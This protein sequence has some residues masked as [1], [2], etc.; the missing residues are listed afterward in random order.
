[1]ITRTA[2]G[3]KPL[4]AYA[5]TVS[6]SRRTGIVLHHSVTATGKTQADVESILRQIDDQ[7]RAKGWGGIGYNLAVD[8]AGRIYEARGLNTLG[9]HTAGA[10][11]P[12]Y[13][14]VY[15]GD[16]RKT[17]PTAAIDAIR[18]CVITCRANTGRR[19]PVR[20]HSALYA[21][22][23]PGRNLATLIHTNGDFA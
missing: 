7:H 4:T 14:I 13:G 6:P 16:G 2:W 8:Y 20:P 10:N 5:T 3:A 23:C 11:T 19:L 21:T 17:V 12:N 1:M 18:A 22:E 9:A 15:I